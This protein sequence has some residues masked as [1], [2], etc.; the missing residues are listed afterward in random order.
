MIQRIGA[1]C[2]GLIILPALV[3]GSSLAFAQSEIE[4]LQ[5][6]IAE[7][8]ERLGE[9]EAEIAQFEAALQEVGAEKDTLQRAIDQ[10]NLERQKV[11]ADIRYTENQ[12][13]N[14]DLSIN[15]LTLEISAAERDIETAESGIAEIIRSLHLNDN[16]TLVEIFLRHENLS[17]FWDEVESLETVRDS[18][19]QRVNELASLKVTLEEK[20]SDETEKRTELD[21]LR[22][23]Y[24]GQQAILDSNRA[25]KNQLLTETNN[26]EASYQLMLTERR[27]AREQLLREVQ[28][29]ESELQFILDPNKIPTPGT[30]V[31]RWPLESIRLTQ[32]FGY[33]KFA[34]ANRGVYRNN[35]HNGIDLAAPVG[36]KIYAP[37][38]GT[39]RNV[40]NT[41]AVPGCYSWGKW[42]LI[43]HPNGLSTLFAH[44]SHIGVSP[45]EKVSTGDVV[46]FTG[47]T[48]FSTGPHLHY[49]LY[50]SEA[51]QVKRFNEFKAV[52]GCGA[53]LSPFAAVE[54][55]LDPLDYL[56]AP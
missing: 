31:F 19:N 16:D 44:L 30:A 47:N 54:G 17:D 27:E 55:Y 5:S 39:I 10:L 1:F 53:A 8:N 20:R 11:L 40:G 28:E 38:S 22:Q 32:Y 29:I 52:T 42:L 13:S 45:G 46:G 51:V 7:R 36:T 43:D 21:S 37:L 25:E 49:T 2:A 3:W 50:V 35:M 33:T 6:E 9:I 4:R 15:K 18:M 34:L 26:E 23:Q 24:T 12:I 41:D 14:T 48:G 56:P